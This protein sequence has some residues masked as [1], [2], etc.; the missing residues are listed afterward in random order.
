MKLTRTMRTRLE[1]ALRNA[2]RA[3]TFLQRSDV[4]VGRRGGPATT[5]V[6]YVRP[7]DGDTFYAIDKDIGSDLCGLQSAITELR[8]VLE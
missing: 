1:Y 8:S 3:Q 5:T 2:E 4:A 7:A 6:H